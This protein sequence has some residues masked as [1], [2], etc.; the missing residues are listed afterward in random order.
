[1]VDPA[2]IC[3]TCGS[4]MRLSYSRIGVHGY[5]VRRRICTGA[6][7][8]DKT[9]TVELPQDLADRVLDP[10]RAAQR[11]SVMHAINILR[12]FLK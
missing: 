9:S 3:T 6:E 7:C 4:K 5:R 8:G 11:E 1:M 2:E 12:D 10:Y